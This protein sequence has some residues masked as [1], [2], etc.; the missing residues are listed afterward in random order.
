VP[1]AILDEFHG[2][3]GIGQQLVVRELALRAMAVLLVA[4]AGLERTE[5]AEFALHRDAAEMGHIGDLFG[6]ADIVVPVGGGLAVS[7]Q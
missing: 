1:I 4:H 2:F 3:V 6:D 5:H 7:L